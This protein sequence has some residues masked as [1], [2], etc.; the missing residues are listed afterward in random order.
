MNLVLK[1]DFSF[2]NSQRKYINLLFQFSRIGLV[3]STK[4]LKFKEPKGGIFFL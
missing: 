2:Q 3:S 1:I 4:C